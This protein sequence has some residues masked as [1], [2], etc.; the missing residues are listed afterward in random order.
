[1]I[2][3]F[4]KKL[5]L[6]YV[7]KSSA[8]C[9]QIIL[10]NNLKT[11]QLTLWGTSNRGKFICI[12]I[13]NSLQQIWLGLTLFLKL[14]TVLDGKRKYKL[15]NIIILMNF[16]KTTTKTHNNSTFLFGML[17][18]RKQYKKPTQ[19]NKNIVNNPKGW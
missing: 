6:Q 3:T 9:I 19:D 18:K 5:N 4:V 17:F 8:V 16:I 2:H 13:K 10:F 14:T 15:L 11:K 12:Y 1:M 7:I